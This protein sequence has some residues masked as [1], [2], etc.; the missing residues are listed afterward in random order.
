MM[1]QLQGKWAKFHAD[2]NMWKRYGK[3]KPADFRDLQVKNAKRGCAISHA[4]TGSHVTCAVLE[5]P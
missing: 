4:G 3:E 1:W 2:P 5:V